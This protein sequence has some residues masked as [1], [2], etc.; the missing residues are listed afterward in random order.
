LSTAAAGRRAARGYRAR[1]VG[2]DE[3]GG[4]TAP[5]RLDGLILVAPGAGEGDGAV[6]DAFGLLRAAGP[7]LRRAGA[8]TGA[9][10]VTVSQLDGA[11]GT[12]D[13]SADVEP[14]SGGL[15]GLAKTA[16]H[17]WPEVRCQALDVDPAL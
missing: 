15:A 12:R 2:R 7:A 11:F 14:T 9:V 17:E 16:G 6:K 4:V 5:A 8:E 3:V 10:L 13:L 1:V